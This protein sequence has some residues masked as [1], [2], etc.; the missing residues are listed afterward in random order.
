L[1][2]FHADVFDR[3]PPDKPFDL[4]DVMRDLVAKKQLAGYEVKERF[5]EIGSPAGLAEL[6][7]LLSSKGSPAG[8]GESRPASWQTYPNYQRDVGILPGCCRIC[9]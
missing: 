6:D 9:L 7:Q 4:A 3:Y 8:N 1:S 2:I 5:Y